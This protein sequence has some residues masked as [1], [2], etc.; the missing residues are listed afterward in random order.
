MLRKSV[1]IIVVIK[2]IIDGGLG[3][4]P[5]AAGGFGGLRAKFPA[6]GRFL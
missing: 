2:R 6:S 3:A 4:E 1:R 5:P